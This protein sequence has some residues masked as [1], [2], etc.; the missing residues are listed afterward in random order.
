MLLLLLDLTTQEQITMDLI[1]SVN[2]QVVIYI[3]ETG[4]TL[5]RC[6]LQWYN[7]YNSSFL[8]HD[9]TEYDVTEIKAVWQS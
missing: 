8:N 9:V 1:I 7:L 4:I 2:G 5:F 6:K 3:S